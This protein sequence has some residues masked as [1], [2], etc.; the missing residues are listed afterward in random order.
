MLQESPWSQAL[1]GTPCEGTA[2]KDH[3]QARKD[4]GCGQEAVTSL[5]TRSQAATATSADEIIPAMRPTPHVLTAS[6][7]ID[8]SITLL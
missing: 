2:H 4:C 8:V 5:H 7:R 3:R 6:C 1:L